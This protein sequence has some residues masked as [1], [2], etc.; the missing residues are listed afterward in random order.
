MHHRHLLCILASFSKSLMVVV[1]ISMLGSA[2]L[3]FFDHVVK[4][5]GAYSHDVLSRQELFI[6]NPS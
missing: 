3:I 4:I 2:H 6:S 5:N 1:E